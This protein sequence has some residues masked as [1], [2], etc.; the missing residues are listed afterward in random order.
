MRYEAS[1]L[2]FAVSTSFQPVFGISASPGAA[3]GSVLATFMAYALCLEKTFQ[4]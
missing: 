3:V 1:V 4:K 2:P